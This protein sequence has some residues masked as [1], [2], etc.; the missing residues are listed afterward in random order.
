MREE[1]RIIGQILARYPLLTRNDQD[2]LN[3]WLDI[4]GNREIFNHLTDKGTRLADLERF[5]QIEETREIAKEKLF[6]Q[7][8]ELEV[9][10]AGSGKTYY[11]RNNWKLYGAAAC[12]ALMLSFFG[13]RWIFRGQKQKQPVEQ[14]ILANN[15]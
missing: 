3:A 10:E 14:V 8:G 4:A 12:L 9:A 11:W 5:L 1:H 15:E 7:N 2:V 13:Y 6:I